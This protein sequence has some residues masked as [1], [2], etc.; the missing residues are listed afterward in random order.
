MSLLSQAIRMDKMKLQEMIESVSENKHVHPRLLQEIIW[1]S[2]PLIER[3][4][5]LETKLK[6]DATITCAYSDAL[7]FS[8]VT[9]HLSKFI[10]NLSDWKF[11]DNLDAELSFKNKLEHNF[12]LIKIFLVE[13]GYAREYSIETDISNKMYKNFY[14]SFISCDTIRE[15]LD[16]LGDKNKWSNLVKYPGVASFWLF[17]VQSKPEQ[18][19]HV[20]TQDYVRRKLFEYIKLVTENFH[21][22]LTNILNDFLDEMLFK[23]FVSTDIGHF[24]SMF[25]KLI[26]E[27]KV[28]KEQL[29]D[30]K[31][32]CNWV[33]SNAE[34]IYKKKCTEVEEDK[35]KQKAIEQ[36]KEFNIV[37]STNE[38]SEV[39][40]EQAK[41]MFRTG[42][43]FE[44]KDN[45]IKAT[46]YYKASYERFLLYRRH[47]LAE[48]NVLESSKDRHLYYLSLLLDKK[49]RAE[50]MS[51]DD[52]VSEPHNPYRKLWNEW[53]EKYMK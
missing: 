6:T 40:Y 34:R 50:S 25:D 19:Q 4:N 38:D 11:L 18:N 7:T 47:V 9:I 53:Q 2:N 28:E 23:K 22:E 43:S 46:E 13:F 48:K 36:V 32:F 17:V 14:D 44:K 30:S 27:K 15:L 41:S 1:F 24:T 42:R 49:N 29:M 12:Q 52:I 39:I 37:A 10:N 31:K 5:S 45:K 8:Q 21:N 35:K 51:T 20:F 3:L 16:F 33:I 26:D